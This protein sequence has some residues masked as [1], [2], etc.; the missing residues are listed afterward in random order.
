MQHFHLEQVA[1]DAREHRARP[2]A[3]GLAAAG[4]AR[5]D[6]GVRRLVVR[7]QDP[8]EVPRGL[9]LDVVVFFSTHGL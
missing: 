5:G 4:G 3:L 6:E 8:P 9:D 1:D 2:E 7:S